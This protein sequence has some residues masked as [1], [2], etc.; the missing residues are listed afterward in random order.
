MTTGATLHICVTIPNFLALEHVRPCP[1]FDEVQTQPMKMRDGCYD[2][3]AAS[4]LGVELNDDVI[5]ANPFKDRP[6]IQA[7]GAD[8]TPAHA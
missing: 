6:V 8:G 2:L 3:P 1:L 7:F 4:G 5:A